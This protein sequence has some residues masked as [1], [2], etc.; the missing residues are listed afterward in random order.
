MAALIPDMASTAPVSPSPQVTSKA[1]TDLIRLIPWDPD[2]IDHV[3]MLEQQRMAC[4]WK[5]EAVEGWKDLQRAGQ[6]GM[7]WVVS[8]AY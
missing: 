5:L 3:E 2:S 4:G 6:I 7:H 1:S 8:L